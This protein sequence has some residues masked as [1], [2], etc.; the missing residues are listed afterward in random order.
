MNSK[1]NCVISH[2]SLKKKNMQYLTSFCFLKKKTFQ[3]PWKEVTGSIFDNNFPIFC[4]DL[5]FT[6]LWR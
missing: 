4:N 1:L 5:D 2:F 3:T 6:E